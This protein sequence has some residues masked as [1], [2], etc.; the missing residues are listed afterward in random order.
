MPF[1]PTRRLVVLLAS[2][3]LL[4]GIAYAQQQ[5]KP[6]PTAPAAKTAKKENKKADKAPA[7][8]PKAAAKPDTIVISDCVVTS[9][10]DLHTN[11][12]RKINFDV[13]DL[14]TYVIY[15]EDPALF[16]ADEQMFFVSAQ[17]SHAP[18]VKVK[19]ISGHP[20]Y[21]YWVIA[22]SGGCD[23]ARAKKNL[24]KF[25]QVFGDPNEIYVP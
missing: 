13:Q 15:V 20:G 21:K 1:V 8:N 18:T 3:I 7:A 9:G 5:T 2:A 17:H 11:N 4:L 25:K 19:D 24:K 23:G 12:G 22:C 14:N 10:R 16:G 6:E